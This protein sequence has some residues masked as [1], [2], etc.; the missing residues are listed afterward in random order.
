MR[1][2][3]M[4]SLGQTDGFEPLFATA[5]TVA[6]YSTSATALAT[7]LVAQT[8]SVLSHPI[9]YKLFYSCRVLCTR[10]VSLPHANSLAELMALL[11]EA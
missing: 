5:P 3:V 9:T 4:A 10:F 2:F 1:L 8:L 7:S 11:L 6:P